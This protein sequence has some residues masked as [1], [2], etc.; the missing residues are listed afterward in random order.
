MLQRAAS[1]VLLASMCLFQAY[2]QSEQA[3][4]VGTVTDGKGA[5]IPRA[6]VTVRGDKGLSRT[7]T[8]SDQG[9][10]ILPSLPPGRYTVAAQAPGLGPTEIVV[11]LGAGQ[12]RTV[13]LVLQPA[14]LQQEI[15][16]SGGDLVVID[17]SSARMGA[18]VSQREVGA[19]P[20]N[21]RQLS[22]LYLMAPGA[23]NNGSG[24]YDSIRFS[25]RSNQQNAIRYDGVEG[26][27]IIDASPGNLN[28]EVTSPFRLQSSLENVQEFRVESNNYPAEYGTGTG[29]QIGIVTKSGS[30]Q[31][32]GALFDYVR[33]DY[34][35]ARNFFD[36]TGKSPLKVNQFGGSLGGPVVRNRL[37]FFGSYEGLRQRAGINFIETVPSA[38]ARARAVPSIAPLVGAFPRGSAPTADPDF[39]AAFLNTSATVAENAGGLRLDHKISDKYSLFAR[40]SRDQGESLQPL[41]VTGNALRI[42][43]VPQNAAVSLQQILSPT[44]INETKVG[45]NAYKTHGNGVA[46]QVP[47]I[48]LSAISIN[49][50]GSVAL[51]GIAGQGTSAGV[52]T[53]GGLVRAN[54]ATNGRGQPYTNYSVSFLDN[55]TWIRG[56][57]AA[58]L[59][60]EVRPLRVYTDRNRSSSWATS[61]RPA[62]STAAR[63]ASAKP[64]RPTTSAMRRTSGGSDPA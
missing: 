44:V 62:R 55:L 21:G 35:D 15:T 26:T 29:G 1:A 63:P 3:R 42:T 33:N 20:L 56:Q 14:T 5:V 4:I 49:I 27:A 6:T 36:R 32:H 64:S 45:L 25:G 57:H 8:A 40:Y 2:A 59:G 22:Q 47:G 53:P 48:D 52:A 61:A 10:Y 30:N 51:P 41:G 19:L 23:V 46:P 13:V 54:S 24:A 31:F 50:S 34:F 60:V 58:K 16:V 39:D 38:A 18:N 17:V 7:W 37:F 9:N 28:G 12:E 11:T 43:A